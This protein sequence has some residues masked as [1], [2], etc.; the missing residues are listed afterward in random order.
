MQVKCENIQDVALKKHLISA[1]G[2]LKKDDCADV[3]SSLQEEAV[4]QRSLPM[5]QMRQSRV[6]LYNWDRLEFLKPLEAGKGLKVPVDR[7]DQTPI[8]L[9]DLEPVETPKEYLVSS[10]D[11]CRTHSKLRR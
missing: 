2:F 11:F 8:T 7:G 3:S 4:F 5:A 10:P 1:E 6:A 9:D